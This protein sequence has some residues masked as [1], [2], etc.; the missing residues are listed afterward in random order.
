MA[1]DPAMIVI[2]LLWGIVCLAFFALFAYLFVG[3]AWSVMRRWSILVFAGVIGLAVVMY[4][5]MKAEQER[6]KAQRAALRAA[7]HR[8]LYE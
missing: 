7:I 5:S 4:P 1:D 6:K 3:F 8:K 2:K